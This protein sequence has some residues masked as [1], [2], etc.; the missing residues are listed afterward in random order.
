MITFYFY[1]NILTAVC[2]SFVE[3]FIIKTFQA[4]FLHKWSVLYTLEKEA[5]AIQKANCFSVWK[6]VLI[7]L[8][9]WLQNVYF[10]LFGCPILIATASLI[11]SQ[12]QK[13][14]TTLSTIRL[15]SLFPFLAPS[16]TCPHS[17]DAQDIYLLT[18]QLASSYSFVIILFL[19]LLPSILCQ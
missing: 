8:I 18:I 16:L 6:S 15:L 9:D 19:S 3:H 4:G 10:S 5:E 2:I 11:E 13:R 17:P 12:G 7:S 14:V 1:E